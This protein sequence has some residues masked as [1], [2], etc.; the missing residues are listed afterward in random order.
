MISDPL[1]YLITFRAYGTWL[2]GDD[3]GSV[4]RD[5][6]VYGTPMLASNQG[7]QAA[8]HSQLRH[9]PVLLNKGHRAIV[10][11]SVRDVC[12]VRGWSLLALNVRSNH[13]HAVVTA[14]VPP[15]RVMQAL[16]SNSTRELR[17]SQLADAG[18]RLW[19]RHGSTKYLWKPQQVEEAC[20]YVAESQGEDIG[21]GT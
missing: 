9:P 11:E 6:N 8:E 18:S 13:V 14:P 17:A 12:R 21:D 7:L 3:R 16:E 15:E 5:H 20:R 1:A 19:S 10:A 2:H 4:N